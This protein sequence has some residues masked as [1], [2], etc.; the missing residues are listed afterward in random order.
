MLQITMN[1]RTGASTRDQRVST[2]WTPGAPDGVRRVDVVEEYQLW[3]PWLDPV[4]INVGEGLWITVLP[5]GPPV[6]T[7]DVRTWRRRA[8]A[9]GQRDGVVYAATVRYGVRVAVS[10]VDVAVVAALRDWEAV[11]SFALKGSR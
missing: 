2:G 8:E 11:Q 5:Y 7:R 4:E 6:E 3:W 1:E 10:M 9:Q